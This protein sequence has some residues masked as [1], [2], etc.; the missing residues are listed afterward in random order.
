MKFQEYR[1]HFYCYSD[2][3]NMFMT[4]INTSTYTV[5]DTW[6][7]KNIDNT[8]FYLLF[9]CYSNLNAQYTS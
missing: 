8:L 9:C 6:N 7:S 5:G 2:Y 3:T 1:H 4:I